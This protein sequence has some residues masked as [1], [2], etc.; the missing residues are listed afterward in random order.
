[1]QL[2]SKTTILH[3]S[4]GLSA[5]PSLGVFFSA[6]TDAFLHGIY[7]F[8]YTHPVK[9]CACPGCCGTAHEGAAG[10]SPG[11]PQLNPRRDLAESLVVVLT[12]LDPPRYHNRGIHVA[13]GGFPRTES[14]RKCTQEKLLCFPVLA[15]WAFCFPLP[16]PADRPGGASSVI[17]ARP[18][19]KHRCHR[20][21]LGHL[22]HS[23][24][25]NCPE[26]EQRI[27]TL[28]NTL[29]SNTFTVLSWELGWAFQNRQEQRAGQKGEVTPF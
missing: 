12:K 10:C 1:M 6:A 18:Q 11:S 25:W 28:S 5:L 2:P 27:A 14:E 23:Q 3:F 21:S 15:V 19:R 16:S 26:R 20:I 17:M 22:G 7:P 9:V 13:G 4:Y 8:P 24:E 29:Q